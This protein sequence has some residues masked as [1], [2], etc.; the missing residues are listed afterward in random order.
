MCID[1]AI[2]WFSESGSAAQEGVAAEGFMDR[3]IGRDFRR[4]GQCRVPLAAYIAS[5][6]VILTVTSGCLAEDG[7]STPQAR[8]FDSALPLPC[9]NFTVSGAVSG[10]FVVDVNDGADGAPLTTRN[11]LAHALL[12]EEA[13]SFFA[14]T[15][16]HRVIPGFMV[17]AGGFS[18]RSDGYQL[19]SVPAPFEA[20]PL[21]SRHGLHNARGTIAMARTNDPNSATSQFY[22]NLVR[23]PRSHQCQRVSHTLRTYCTLRASGGQCELRLLESV[24]SRIL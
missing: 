17:Q 1:S 6:L 11:F 21:E 3:H 12:D 20:I 22:I 14:G 5:S 13:G 24:T 15:V 18:L 16:F 4:N 9:L 23:V 8:R 19:R 2:I 7:A 10:A